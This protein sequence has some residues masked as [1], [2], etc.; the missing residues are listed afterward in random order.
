MRQRAAD[1]H[2]LIPEFETIREASIAKIEA[3][4][5]LKRL[6][7]HPQDGGFSLKQEDRRVV[8]AEKHLEKMAADFK[9]LTELQEVRSAAWQT[10]SAALANVETWL[11]HGLPGNCT[12]EPTDTEP[13][14]LAKGE[15]VTDAIERLRR[16]GRELRAD[17]HRIESAPFPSSYAKQ[18]MREQIEAL[19]MQ[20]E[21]DVTNLIEHDGKIDFQMQRVTSEVHAEKRALAFTEVL[22]AAALVAWVIKDALVKRLDAKIA[23]E[24]DDPAALSHEARQQREAEVQGDLL[25]VERD[26]AALVWQAQQSLLPV[27][28]RSDIS[29]LALLGLQLITAPRATNG[30][31]SPERAGFNLVGGRR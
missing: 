13:P 10:T 7:D 15:T 1:A 28:H 16:R 14:K 29:P 4:N 12:L 22:D 8:S 24:A 9:R 3:A 6:T 5:A 23:A 26:E 21:P 30:P 25:A 11:R 17:L 31:S 19:A 20:G 18:R 2:R 27:E